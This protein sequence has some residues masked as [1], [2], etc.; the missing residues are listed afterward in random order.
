MS[1]KSVLYVKCSRIIEI[2]TGKKAFDLLGSKQQLNKL[3]FLI[4]VRVVGDH[5]PVLQRVH[6]PGYILHQPGRAIQGL[7]RI[8][9]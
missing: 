2:G 1:A 6:A 9:L 8:K 5:G 4:S 3:F 7:Y